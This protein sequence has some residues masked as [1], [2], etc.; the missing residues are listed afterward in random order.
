[1]AIV[2]AVL[3]YNPQGIRGELGQTVIGRTDD[4]NVLKVLKD[5]IISKAIEDVEMWKD[6]DS[7]ITSVYQADLKK[8]VTI[9]SIILPK[10]DLKPNLRALDRKLDKED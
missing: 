2:E 1:M 10:E 7:G 5:G 4:P 3:I 9:L 6:I 8:L